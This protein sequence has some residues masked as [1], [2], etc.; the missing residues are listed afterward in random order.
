MIGVQTKF[1]P[2]QQKVKQAV[3]TAKFKNLQHSAFSIRKLAWS[4]IGKAPQG[5]PSPVGT[6]PHTHKGAYYRR[7]LRV[8][9]DRGRDEALIGFMASVVGKTA[10]KHEHGL[11]DDSGDFTF[12][13]RP[14]VGPAL[15]D[16]LGR[17]GGQWKGS[18]GS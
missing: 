6:A 17:I 14:T 18:I 12:P 11:R 1:T 4:R 10:A 16:S 2:N 5:K 15:E 3:N 13:K 9:V 8:E 7:A